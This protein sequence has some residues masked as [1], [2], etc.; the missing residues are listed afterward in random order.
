MYHLITFGP[1]FVSIETEVVDKNIGE[2]E[3]I[4][5]PY[6]SYNFLFVYNFPI[7]SLNLPHLILSQRV[8]H[9]GSDR[10]SRSGP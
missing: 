8:S 6:V 5:H 7:M 2:I 10:R 1:N 3:D 9:Q 4:P